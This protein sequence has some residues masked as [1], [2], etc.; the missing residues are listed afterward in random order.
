MVAAEGI[1]DSAQQ[2]YLIRTECEQGRGRLYSDAISAER[3]LGVIEAGVMGLQLA[4]R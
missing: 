2:A 3:T 4:G 1:Q